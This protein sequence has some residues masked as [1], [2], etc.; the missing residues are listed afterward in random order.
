MK[1][2]NSILFLPILLGLV[3]LAQDVLAQGIAK[4]MTVGYV[5][6]KVVDQADEGEGSWGWGSNSMFW[7]GYTEN[8]LYSSKA[9]MLGCK[10]WT[11]ENGD[12]SPVP[13]GIKI[14]GHGQLEVDDQHII[15]PIPDETGNTINRYYRSA[16]PA[17]TVDGLPI[18]TFFPQNSADEV[19]PEKI[20]GSADGLIESYVNSDMGVSFKQRAIGFSQQNHNKYIIKE[21]I[22]KNTGNTDLDEEI[23]LNQ[24]I[25]GFYFLKQLRYQEWP[26]RPWASAVGQYPGDEVRMIYGYPTREPGT[27]I[28]N[29]GAPN[30]ANGYLTNPIFMGEALL[31]ASAAPNDFDNDHPAQPHMTGF[32]DVDFPSF[33]FH[34]WNMTTSQKS[35][36]YE[37]MENGLINI[38][39]INW[40]E[41]EG[42]VP[43]THHGV[44][45]DEYDIP[46]ITEMPGF[47]F[48]S[49]GTYSVGPYDL[50]PGDSIKIVIADC[51]GGISPD[52]TRE[53]SEKWWNN[54]D[55]G[56]PDG[57]EDNAKLPQQYQD[58]PELYAADER[59]EIVNLNKDKW[60]LSGKDSLLQSARAAKWALM[61][62]RMLLQGAI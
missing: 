23:E 61:P 58:F 25:E 38:E 42:T 15:M 21:Y 22:F 27:E 17:L 10:N 4:E 18:S 11:D 1:Y 6:F 28:D 46:Y 26:Q 41:L 19:A 32:T 50:A 55:P 59:D 9:V 29:L 47:G 8:S 3:I 60:V 14:S 16:L 12:P 20:P 35:N 36:L 7:D 5:R 30:D 37:V 54:E 39:G 44:P 52:V 34:S 2:R 53:V 62:A 40:V 57:W 51:I 33:T 43:G 24:T 45:M 31:F 48:S 13:G 56:V 49:S